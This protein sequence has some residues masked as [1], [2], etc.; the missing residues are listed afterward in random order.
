MPRLD[1]GSNARHGRGGPRDFNCGALRAEAN[2]IIKSIA[3]LLSRTQR[4]RHSL[5]QSSQDERRARL[6]DE[7]PQACVRAA[8]NTLAISP[9]EHPAGPRAGPRRQRGGWRS[10]LL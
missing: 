8:W 5:G 6:R 3:A 1:L 7:S 10:V 4:A 2:E 9:I